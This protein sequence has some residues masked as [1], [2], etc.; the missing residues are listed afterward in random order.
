MSS[1][2]WWTPK[3]KRRSGRGNF[4][5][6]IVPQKRENRGLPVLKGNCGHP[7][8]LALADEWCTQTPTLRTQNTCTHHEKRQHSPPPTHLHRVH[9]PP[10]LRCKIASR[11]SHLDRRCRAERGLERCAELGWR[12]GPRHGRRA[13][14]RRDHGGSPIPT[15]SWQTQ[16]SSGSLLMRARAPSFYPATG[17]LPRAAS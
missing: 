11:H 10:W 1:S 9:R 5:G 12:S 8:K 13:D 6:G 14:F 2:P 16:L 15:T 4:P 17:S 7:Q 3:K